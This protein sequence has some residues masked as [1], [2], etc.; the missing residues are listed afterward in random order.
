MATK[1]WLQKNNIPYIEKN[2]SADDASRV[3]LLGLGYRTTPVVVTGS[4]DAIVGYN[5]SKFANA[6]L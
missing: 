3:E 4:G 1:S 5:P 2:I 6:L